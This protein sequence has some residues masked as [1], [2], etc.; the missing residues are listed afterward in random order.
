MRRFVAKT[1]AIKVALVLHDEEIRTGLAFLIDNSPQ[2][3]CIARCAGAEELLRD[4]PAD[5]CDVILMNIGLPG[6]SGIEAIQHLKHRSPRT[7]IMM[8]TVSEEPEQ[9]FQSLAAGATGYLLK[10]TPPGEVLEAIIDLHNGGSPMSNPVARRVVEVFRKPVSTE[11]AA[12]SP[13][14]HQILEE[15]ATGRLYKEIAD[16]LA[17]TTET[18]R[19][20][21]RNIYEKLHVRTRSEAI[22]KFLQ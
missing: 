22:L 4:W 18:V 11:L 10:D 20:H 2:T 15:L 6:M 12:L 8:L 21:L 1:N 19:T 16:T 7:Q 14:E 3:C 13:R 9:I 5:G 17:I